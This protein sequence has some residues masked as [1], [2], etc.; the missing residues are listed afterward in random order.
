M[1]D[2]SEEAGSG[3]KGLFS[4]E[5]SDAKLYTMDIPVLPMLSSIVFPDT[6]VSIQISRKKNLA[7]TDLTREGEV[8]CLLLQKNAETL[9]P[10]STDLYRIGVTA[11]LLNKL[12]LSEELYQVFLHG[13]ERVMVDTFVSWEHYIVAGIR[14]LHGDC[15][16][17]DTLVPLR[18]RIQDAVD[19]RSNRRKYDAQQ[20]LMKFA[21]TVRDETD[22]EA[23]SQELINEVNQTMQPRMVTLWLKKPDN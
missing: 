6:I 18:N 12:R 2:L 17:D 14:P 3:N 8:I 16:P 23:L 7:L 20:V 13:L 19:R 10:R 15:P 22:V 5:S 11:R 1:K 21:E 4:G 9:E